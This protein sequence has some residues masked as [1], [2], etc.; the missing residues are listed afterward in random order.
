M[1]QQNKTTEVKYSNVRMVIETIVE[2]ATDATDE[3]VKAAATAEVERRFAGS[4]VHVIKSEVVH[5][6][7][8]E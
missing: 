8:S 3:Q 4:W 6:R 7:T 5:Q 1:A 2:T